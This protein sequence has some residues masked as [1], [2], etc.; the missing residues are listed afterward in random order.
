MAF[1]RRLGQGNEAETFEDGELVIKLYRAH[2]P[3]RW[4]FREAALL[5]ALEAMG[6]PV[7]S[8]VAGRAIDGRWGLTMTRI[9]GGPLMER[10]DHNDRGRRDAQLADMA[11]LHMSIHAHP[12]TQF[13]SMTARLAD[14]IRSV[15]ALDDVRKADLLATLAARPERARLCHGDFHPFNVL[16][17]EGRE[18]IIDWPNACSGDPLADVCRSY[19]LMK[20]L[21]PDYASDYVDAYCAVA[22]QSRADILDW[23]PLIA[24]ARLA[25]GDP[26]QTPR[27]LAMIDGTDAP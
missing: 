21:T 11:R 12:G 27:L 10:L 18:T 23:L 19:V 22:G 20:S 14:A 16:G 13:A 8:A 17:P 9:H 25:E 15:A 26:T 3:K 6:L 5:S 7:P 24:A 4:A 2:A 1:G